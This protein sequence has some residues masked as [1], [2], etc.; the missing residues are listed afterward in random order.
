M[1]LEAPAALA[2]REPSMREPPIKNAPWIDII[3]SIPHRFT[4]VPLLL[5]HV[6]PI[7]LEAFFDETAY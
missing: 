7:K 5:T 6:W 2:A 3:F 1:I 4:Y